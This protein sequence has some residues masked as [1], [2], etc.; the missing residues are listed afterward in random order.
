MGKFSY[1]RRKGMKK[2]S[3]KNRKKS[4]GNNHEKEETKP[5]VEEQTTPVEEQTTPVEEQTATGEGE[6][7]PVEEQNETSDSK[8]ATSSEEVNENVDS[9]SDD[10]QQQSDSTDLSKNETTTPP[11]ED[12]L[13]SEP[14]T[15]EDEKQLENADLDPQAIDDLAKA[16]EKD[17]NID[18]PPWARVAI[19]SGAAGKAAEFLNKHPELKKALEQRAISAIQNSGSGGPGGPVGNAGPSGIG[20]QGTSGQPGSS[21]GLPQGSSDG[22]TKFL[23]DLG[24][25][26]N[27][28]AVKSVLTQNLYI[29]ANT[30]NIYRASNAESSQWVNIRDQSG[31]STPAPSTGTG[32]PG[33]GTGAP[34]TGTDGATTDETTDAPVE[35]TDG[36]PVEQTQGATTGETTDAPNAEQNAPVSSDAGQSTNTS[37]T[38]TSSP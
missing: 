18:L 28:D 6:N 2:Q 22:F 27:S 36:A 30:Q 8:D 16:L 14:L 24:N 35:G 9:T 13:Q 12:G 19:K 31:K 1:K 7:A 25:A 3:F 29:M 10:R 23:N 20:T 11:P 21:S 37:E 32:A 17:P 33:A 26:N 38:S 34:S 5:V 15:S 4:G